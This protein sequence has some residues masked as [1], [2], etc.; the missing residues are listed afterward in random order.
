MNNKSC[1]VYDRPFPS[2]GEFVDGWKYFLWILQGPFFLAFNF[3]K[4]LNHDTV[5]R[6]WC[7]PA[8]WVS[9][10]G[11]VIRNLISYAYYTCT[12]IIFL[13]SPPS[14]RHQPQRELKLGTPLVVF[15]LSS[16][17]TQQS[18]ILIIRGSLLPCSLPQ[19]Q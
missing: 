15:L 7:K 14:P 16:A 4:C 10:V 11:F 1:H 6:D 5:S 18:N 8:G 13:S 19:P 3:K 12:K 17:D 2:T 9:Y